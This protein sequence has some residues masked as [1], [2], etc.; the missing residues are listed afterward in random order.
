MTMTTLCPQCK[1][2]CSIPDTAMGIE[3]ACSRCQAIFSAKPYERAV[4]AG[5]I[6]A[7]AIRRNALLILVIA[8]GVSGTLAMVAA[9]FVFFFHQVYEFKH[10]VE[11][12]H[13]ADNRGGGFGIGIG[14]FGPDPEV[15]EKNPG[16]E[17]PALTALAFPPAP[18]K[19]IVPAATDKP[20]NLQWLPIVDEFLVTNLSWLEAQEFA[21]DGSVTPLQ[22]RSLV[23]IAESIQAVDA[24]EQ[25]SIRLR[26]RGYLADASRAETRRTTPQAGLEDLTVVSAFMLRSEKGEP[27]A[28]KLDLGRVAKGNEDAVKKLHERQQALNDFFSLPLP[29]LTAARPG[30][31]W[32]Y[33]RV[34]PL[35]CSEAECSM[36]TCALTARLRGS[37]RSGSGELAVVEL[38]GKLKLDRQAEE[39]RGWALIN[40]ATGIVV[41][42]QAELPF[43][44]TPNANQPG[45]YIKGTLHLSFQRRVPAPVEDNN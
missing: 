8:L 14:P 6:K 15:E 1:A 44:L 17:K 45:R 41:D 40:A 37:Q 13:R 3:V 26:F 11:V 28:H 38:T 30:A 34:V 29:G 12:V 21:P 10:P 9:S 35:Q 23:Q 39:T 33:E 20:V 4:R 31:E 19:F 32:A 24:S 36:P 25:A 43:V 18:P 16:S 27:T 2:I 5:S 7:P 22:S 42:A